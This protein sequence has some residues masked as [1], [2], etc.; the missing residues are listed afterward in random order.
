[1]PVPSS[2]Q[3]FSGSLLSRGRQS[4]PQEIPGY[5]D[6]KAFVN[7]RYAGPVSNC[8]E[9]KLETGGVRRKF[10]AEQKFEI[11]KNIERCRTNQGRAGQVSDRAILV[12]KWKR[13]LKVGVRASLRQGAPV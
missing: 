2:F 8:S 10:T 6:G 11:L 13:Q 9:E 5:Y 3:V 1:M 7:G 12:S 4:A